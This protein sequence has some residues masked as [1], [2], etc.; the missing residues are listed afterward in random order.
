[1]DS[2]DRIEEIL[3][4]EWRFYQL[5]GGPP[6][7]NGYTFVSAFCGDCTVRGGLI[8]PPEWWVE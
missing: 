7:V 2:E 4:G 5:E 1:M 8:S 3:E 6:Q